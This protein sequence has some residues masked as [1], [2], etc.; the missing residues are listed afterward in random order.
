MK[1]IVGILAACVL[2][3]IVALS[4]PAS[5]NSEKKTDDAQKK[6]APRKVVVLHFMGEQTKRDGLKLLVDAVTEKNPNLSY[7]IEGVA[8]AQYTGILKT[9]IAADDAPDLFTG[10]PNQYVELIRAGQVMDLS[11]KPYMK[12]VI[13]WLANEG[14]VDG[15]LYGFPLDVQ[16]YG[17]FYNKEVFAKYNIAPPKTFDELLKICDT[18]AA[19]KIYPFVRAYKNAN[20]P[21]VEYTSF[22][23]PMLAQHDSTKNILWQSIFEK[24]AKFMDYPVFVDSMRLYDKLLKYTE[25]GDF[26]VDPAQGRMQLARGERAMLVDGGWVVG[27]LYAASPDGKFGFFPAP[28]SNDPAKNLAPVGLDDVFMAYAKTKNKE[29]VEKFLETAASDT[30]SRIWMEKAKM[31]SSIDGAPVP[32][33]NDVQQDMAKFLAEKKTVQRSRL[34]EFSG[35]YRTKMRANIQLFAA[36][37]VEK[38]AD[39]E[40]FVRDLDAEFA[41]I[42]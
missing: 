36:M 19:N 40:K 2:A 30:G 24:K 6:S 12:K 5:G 10:W 9:R 15:K 18:L 32:K 34:V 1:K 3:C 13:P 23:Y 8:Y 7:E 16:I 4:V 41:L 42:K 39:I 31:I 38:R 14:R 20:F 25:P 28:W 26:G 27:D 37:G 21:W 11:D 35:E 22:S 33:E 29:G 17:I